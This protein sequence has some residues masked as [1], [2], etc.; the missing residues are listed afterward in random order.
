MSEPILESLNEM[1]TYIRTAVVGEEE[2]YPSSFV[3]RRNDPLAKSDDS[4]P[5]IIP[6]VH[7]LMQKQ[8]KCYGGLS[9]P[10]ENVKKLNLRPWKFG[11]T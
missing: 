7:L 11:K 8:V 6:P 1:A 3:A 2:S 5:L 10:H 4:N 9:H